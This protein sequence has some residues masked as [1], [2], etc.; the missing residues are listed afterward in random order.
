MYASFSDFQNSLLPQLPGALKAT[1]KHEF[2][3]A[4]RTFYRRTRAWPVELPG[5]VVPAGRSEVPLNP[6]DQNADVVMLEALCD[7]ATKAR[8]WGYVSDPHTLIVD[9]PQERRVDITVSVMPKVGGDVL[10]PYALTHHYDGLIAGTLA[11]MFGQPRKP[12]SNPVEAQRQEAKLLAEIARAV[13]LQMTAN[14]TASVGWR[15]R[16]VSLR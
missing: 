14:G 6:V 1:V 4:A 5:V 11:A 7:S 10:P 15:F 13:S 9:S 12:Y 2:Y 8:V 3:I 16:P